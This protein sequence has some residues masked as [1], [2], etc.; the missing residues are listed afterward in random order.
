MTSTSKIILGLLAA[1]AAGAAIGVLFAPAKGSD[2]RQQIK[3]KANEWVND[4][5][6]MLNWGSEKAEEAL[7]ETKEAMVDRVQK[8]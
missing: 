8:G 5:A 1:A 7:A 6:D 4:I 2:T 3:D